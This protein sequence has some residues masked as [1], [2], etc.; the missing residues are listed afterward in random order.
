[1]KKSMISVVLVLAMVISM[2]ATVFAVDNDWE[3]EIDTVGAAEVN[4]VYYHDLQAAVDAAGDSVV[5]LLEEPTAAINNTGNLKLNLNGFS[6]TVNG[7]TVTVTD[8]STDDGTVGGKIYGNYDLAQTVTKENGISYV[9]VPGEDSD[10]AYYTANAVRV[11]VKRIS[12]RPSRAGMYYTTQVV[13][14]RNIADLGATYGVALSVVDQPGSN[15]IEDK[16]TLWT[17]FSVEKGANF[18]SE[19]TSCLV[20]D[21]MKKDGSSDETNSARGG[22]EVFANAYVKTQVGDETV[23]VMMENLEV[24]YSLQTVMQALD[25][26]MESELQAY[27]NGTGSLSND[28]VKIVDFF[29]SWYGAMTQNGWDLNNLKA[30]YAKKSAA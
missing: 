2:S 5:T 16:D 28:G 26:K 3:S 10:G 21:I 22:M 19:G 9:A 13:F 1:M 11:R 30:A 18:A 6:A 23:V 27:A 7:G 29:G 25:G 8:S 20:A 24:T 14:N 15:F 12:V 4:G 17:E